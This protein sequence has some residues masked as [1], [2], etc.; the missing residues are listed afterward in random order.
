M[1][2]YRIGRGLFSASGSCRGNHRRRRGEEGDCPLGGVAV[3]TRGGTEKREGGVEGLRS[4]CGGCPLAK[5]PRL[6]GIR[7]AEPV[8]A[9]SC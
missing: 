3:A 5:H 6:F 4:P 9:T 2:T 1:W 8:P 7:G